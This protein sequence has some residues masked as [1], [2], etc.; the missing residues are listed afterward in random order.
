M[1]ATCRFCGKPD[2]I[3]ATL[4]KDARCGACAKRARQRRAIFDV[5]E[6]GTPPR[7]ATTRPD[8]EA[9]VLPSA[10]EE[11]RMLDLRDLAKRTRQALATV[12]E[13]D[14]ADALLNVREAILLV[15]SIAPASLDEPPP[16]AAAPADADPSPPAVRTSSTPARRRLNAIYSGVGLL[17]VMAAM[18]VAKAN[19]GREV[20]SAAAL[21]PEQV[22]TPAPPSTT[23]QPAPTAAAPRAP[24]TAA[25]AKPAVTPP[26]APPRAAPPRP[27]APVAAPA[28]TPE[29]RA[30][31]EPTATPHVELLD[32]MAAAVAA[33]S[34]PPAA[35]KV[36]CPPGAAGGSGTTSPCPRTETK[37]SPTH[38]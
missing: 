3:G 19:M 20:A 34:A 15:D 35:P 2:E 22:E 30:A 14:D 13:K 37:A 9:S 16:I 10:P 29:V 23:T 7:D 6:S 28:D 18:V 4:D 38:P 21:A 33:H 26:R 11:T 5:S 32:A 36:D 27:K 24:A 12:P 31:A 1:D 17:F 8:Q 25:T